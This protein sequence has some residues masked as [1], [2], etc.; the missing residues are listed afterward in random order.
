[1]QS[2]DEW[3]EFFTALLINITI[4]WDMTS[5]WL[6]IIYRRSGKIAASLFKVVQGLAYPDGGNKFFDL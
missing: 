4:F 5:C 6:V 2:I 1:M 3:A